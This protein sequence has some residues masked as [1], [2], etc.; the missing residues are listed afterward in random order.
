MLII[1]FQDL[2]NLLY[3][4]KISNSFIDTNT[5]NYTFSTSDECYLMFSYSK[6]YEDTLILNEGQTLATYESYKEYLPNDV[7][8][9]NIIPTQEIQNVLNIASLTIMM[10]I[11]YYLMH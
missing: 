4:I 1:Q 11:K 7:D 9:S 10:E 6:S 5:T 3:M 2:E 8:L